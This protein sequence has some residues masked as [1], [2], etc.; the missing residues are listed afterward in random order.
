V[1][2]NHHGEHHTGS[3]RSQLGPHDY[4]APELQRSAGIA[5]E[6]FIAFTLPSRMGNRLHWPDGRVTRVDEHPGMPA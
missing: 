5:P 6:R 4:I 1:A 2:Q 3:A